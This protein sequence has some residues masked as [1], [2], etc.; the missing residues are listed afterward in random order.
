MPEATPPAQGLYLGFDFGLSRTGVAVGEAMT[1]SARA[2]ATLAC[3]DGQPNWDEVA[4]L[5]EQWQPQGLVVGVPRHADGSLPKAGEAAQRFARRLEGRFRLPVHTIDE[6]LSS[7]AA[8][9]ELNAAG[10]RGQRLR[11]QKQKID[12]LA[13]GIILETWFAE[14]QR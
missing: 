13:A 1:G 5:L 3:R 7:H 9:R 10:L 2:L 12:S 4:A 11:R 14:Q 6:H 8:E